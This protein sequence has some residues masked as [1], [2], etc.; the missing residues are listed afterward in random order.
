MIANEG[1]DPY[2]L[3]STWQPVGGSNSSESLSFYAGGTATVLKLSA[4]W[5]VSEIFSAGLAYR[6]VGW[7]LG[8]NH[9][10]SDMNSFGVQFRI[11]FSSNTNKIVP[12]FQGSYYFINNNTLTQNQAASGSQVQPAFILS[13]KT[14]IG[15]DADLG[16]EF[17]LGKS[18]ALQATAG[19]G[20]T[21]AT[22]PDLTVT[23]DYGSYQS[24]THIDGVFSYA[25]TGG[26]K[27]Y[28]GRGAKKRDF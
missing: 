8:E 27:Y 24:P 4:M 17:K 26:I 13:Q 12:F 11:N 22:D 2:A 10:S 18:F 28:T 23:L 20:G 21:Q 9:R 3:K 19:F 25:F 5:D 1:N 7:N 6:I 16:I 15:F 14:S